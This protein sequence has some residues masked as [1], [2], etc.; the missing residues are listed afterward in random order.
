T[1]SG[2]TKRMFLPMTERKDY[3]AT[4]M[5]T[6][7]KSLAFGNITT[8]IVNVPTGS[9]NNLT[10]TLTPIDPYNNNSRW[11]YVNKTS[12]GFSNKHV[13][14]NADAPIYNYYTSNSGDHAYTGNGYVFFETP[15]GYEVYGGGIRTKKIKRINS[16][17]EVYVKE[18]TYTDGVATDEA[19]RFEY[20]RLKTLCAESVLRYDY[21]RSKN[22][23]KL[24]MSPM[25]GYSKVIVKD[26]GRIN[27]DNGKI[28]LS[29]IVDPKS[30]GGIFD[31]DHSITTYTSSATGKVNRLMECTNIFGNIFGAQKET[32]IYDK[33]DNMISRSVNVYT[34]TEQGALVEEVYFTNGQYDVTNSINS[35]SVNIL[36]DIPV[37]LKESINYG[38]GTKQISCTLKR[39]ELTGETTTMEGIAMNNSSSNT[40]KVPAYKKYQEIEHLDFEDASLRKMIPLGHDMFSYS[41]VDSTLTGT[42]A[43]GYSNS[44]VGS[45]YNLL[46]KK[47]R[48]RELAS[49][50]YYTTEVTLPYYYNN[51]SFVYDAGTGSNNLYGLL[52]KTTSG[53]DSLPVTALTHS[54]FSENNSSYDWRL[55]NEVTLLDYYKNVVETR[56]ANNRY[57][58]AR[59]GYNGY[60]KSAAASNVNYPSFTFCD[61]ETPPS[62]STNPASIDGDLIINNHTF[63]PYTTVEPHSGSK[64]IQVTST[65]ITYSVKTQKSPGG[66]L[67]IGL[68]PGRI[69]RVGVWVHNTNLNKAEIQVAIT[70]TANSTYQS[71]QLTANSTNNLIATIGNWNLIQMDFEID[72]TFETGINDDVTISLQT[73][74]GSTVYYDDFM[75]HPVESG[76]SASVYNPRN[77][78]VSATLDENGFAT[79][80]KYDAAGRMT[81]VWKEIPDVG[82]KKI[83]KYTYNYARGANN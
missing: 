12:G 29:F 80:Y 30:E 46:S 24:N 64:C 53:L 69:Y 38:M 65:A 54:V 8:T 4:A 36:R 9:S 17:N 39:D 3:D 22:Y 52:S 19:D 81:E 43:N 45:A 7:Y 66:T 35:Y 60:Y 73:T 33:N 28:E 82:Y 49:G 18:Y 55:T 51:R 32:K 1:I 6:V 11:A 26:L 61:F 76:F 13:Y 40:F 34:T 15:I 31:Y 14:A 16:Y 41:N 77:G 68:L 10:G 62:G 75:F 56:D 67:D 47:A 79:K 63:I 21:L 71:T 20:P 27:S 70:G 5:S 74:D 57:N 23:T 25:I 83:K 2:L 59:Y 72:P 48:K 42:L 37:V 78:R 50:L 44:F 58:A